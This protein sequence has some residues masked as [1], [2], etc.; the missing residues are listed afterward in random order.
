MCAST[1]SRGCATHVVRRCKAS[2]S[3]PLDWLGQPLSRSDC[4]SNRLVAQVR[5]PKHHWHPCCHLQHLLRKSATN[6]KKAPWAARAPVTLARRVQPYRPKYYT[7][8]ASGSPLQS[9]PDDVLRRLLAGVS[10][11][12]HGATAVACRAFRAVINGPQFLALRRRYGFAEHDLVIVGGNYSGYG[13]DL[14]IRTARPS[15]LRLSINDGDGRLEL[16]SRGLLYS[17][18]TT[19]GGTRLFVCL[20]SQSNAQS[21]A[22]PSQMDIWSVD[23]SSRTYCCLTTI[24]MRRSLH[25]FEWHDGCLYFAGGFRPPL[26]ATD[27]LHSFQVFNVATGLW[28][29]LP[30]MPQPFMLAASGVIGN[31]LFVAGGRANDNNTSL[32]TLQI[33]DFT[34]RTWRLGA[35]M[36]AGKQESIGVVVDGKLFVITSGMARHDPTISVYDPASETWSVE[37]NTPFRHMRVRYACAHNDRVIV[38]LVS[39]QVFERAAAGTWSIFDLSDEA[40]DVV[41]GTSQTFVESSSIDYMAQTV[42]LG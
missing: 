13:E 30:P 7:P 40:R 32:S 27:F 8:P 21:N 26:S 37:A 24:P 9:L 22:F 1:A 16:S 31:Q 42:L 36:P 20:E 12:D 4:S 18:S 23:M 33:F 3:A 38:F 17:D 25:S 5:L 14:K 34:T 35:P 19:D 6:M 15:G 39:G 41:G 11:L 29:D 10:F 28:G 2:V